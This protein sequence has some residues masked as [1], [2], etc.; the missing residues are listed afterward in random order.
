MTLSIAT[1][2]LLFMVAAF[3]ADPSLNKPAGI[4]DFPDFDDTPDSDVVT[5][6]EA[7]SGSRGLTEAT[8]ITGTTISSDI[9]TNVPKTASSA[10][11]LNVSTSHSAQDSSTVRTTKGSATNDSTTIALTTVSTTTTSTTA[12]S[13]TVST[14][15][16]TEST[17]S[18]SATTDS[19][20]S[21]SSTVESTSSV[22]TTDSPTTVQSSTSTTTDSST[23]SSTTTDSTTNKS[24]TTVS[25]TDSTSDST[26]DNVTTPVSTT[27]SITISTTEQQT[28]EEILFTLLAENFGALI[29]SDS[30]LNAINTLNW[31]ISTD[32]D[33]QSESFS[34]IENTEEL[35]QNTS[36]AIL[37]W[38]VDLL[39]GVVNSIQKIDLFANRSI[40]TVSQLLRFQKLNQDR[41]KNLGNKLDVT[42]GQILLKS[43][44]LDN[45]LNFVSQ[46]LK[47]YIE[48]KVNNLKESFANLNTSQV[49]SLVELKNLPIITNLTETSIIKLSSL[50]NQLAVF[51]QTQESSLY[52]L[53]TAVKDWAPTNFNAINDLIQALSIS[54]KRT[55]LALA[56]CGSSDY[57]PNSYSSD[58]DNYNNYNV[59][60]GSEPITH[61]ISSDED[62]TLPIN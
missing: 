52:S 57:N 39:Q 14:T 50:S 19:I 46:I 24:T 42:Q 6:A 37:S 5:V 9:T 35:L 51:N 21:D 10:G 22:S 20:T 30:L 16:P 58:L 4:E 45:K 8:I 38:E 40:D 43:K 49:N 11:S 25:T 23:L 29:E 33:N 41:V 34:L 13:T 48:P 53:E 1:L 60:I 17:T 47:G 18:S 26:T 32:L 27:D 28:E 62:K 12:V 55:D 59:G 3:A 54:Q 36:Q 61:Q 56:I 15:L 31:N 44:G 2:L 7:S